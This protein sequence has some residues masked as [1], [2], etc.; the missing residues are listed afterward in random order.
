MGFHMWAEVWIDG[1]WIPIDATLGRG[2]IGAAHIK[3][4]DS[5]WHDV[6]SLTPLLPVSRVLGKV[7]IDILSVED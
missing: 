3:I 4:A 6:Q 2:S 1:Q 7:A 5:S